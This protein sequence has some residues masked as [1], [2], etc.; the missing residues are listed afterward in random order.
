[1]ASSL[2]V[3]QFFS[4]IMPEV[5]ASLILSIGLASCR[6][7]NQ[8]PVEPQQEGADSQ[9]QST[10]KSNSVTLI[11]FYGGAKGQSL[12]ISNT[13]LGQVISIVQTPEQPLPPLEQTEVEIDPTE[14]ENPPLPS[15][16]DTEHYEG[17]IVKL[18]ELAKARGGLTPAEESMYQQHMM[19]INQSAKKLAEFQD[20]TALTLENRQGLTQWFDRKRDNTKDKNKKKEEEKKRKKEEEKRKTEEEIKKKKQEKENQKEEGKV[21]E[22]EGED[23]GSDAVAINLPPDDASVAE[24][25]PV[26]L[27]VAGEGGVAASKPIATAVVGPGGLAIAR[28]VG[29][30]IAGVSPDQALV[31]IYAEGLGLGPP[32]KPAK[33]KSDLMSEFLNRIISKYHHS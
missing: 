31:P 27:A 3:A 2:Y 1:M 6:P 30:A 28:P 16:Y 23:Q 32:K 11:P 15:S 22:G 26:G 33:T 25:K 21:E 5:G 13:P 19:S 18:Q 17:E 10:H 12:Q 14:L 29:T 9:V 8:N 7:Q 4:V 20:N 24:A